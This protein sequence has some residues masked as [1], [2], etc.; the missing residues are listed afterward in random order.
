[1]P[2]KN[3][4]FIYSVV[5]VPPQTS[6]EQIILIIYVVQTV[7]V[8]LLTAN[9][10]SLK[11]SYTEFYDTSISR[12]RTPYKATVS[13]RTHCGYVYVPSDSPIHTK[14]FRVWIR[15]RVIY[16]ARKLSTT[17]ERRWG[18][19]RLLLR[20]DYRTKSKTQKKICPGFESGWR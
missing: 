10:T 19:G 6:V 8:G 12:H 13:A 2:T 4:C 18:Q 15:V 16:V 3:Y 5:C 9:G 1:M 7:A 17:K 14:V 20:V 11:T